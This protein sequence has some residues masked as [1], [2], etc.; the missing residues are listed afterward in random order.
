MTSAFSPPL[1]R[2][3]SI[4]HVST[5]FTPLQT[6]LALKIV[7]ELKRFLLYIAFV[8]IFSFLSGLAV[9]ITLA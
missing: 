8:I 5:S 3:L 9:N 7:F 1:T 2:L 6:A 4:R